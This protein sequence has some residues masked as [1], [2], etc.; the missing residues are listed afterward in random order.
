M[1]DIITAGLAG[2]HVKVDYVRPQLSEAMAKE[3][4]TYP[5][6]AVYVTAWEAND[7]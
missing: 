6:N 3:L 1:N 2:N 5:A 7:L 4:K